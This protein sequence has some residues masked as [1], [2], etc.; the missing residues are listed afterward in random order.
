MSAPESDIGNPPLSQHGIHPK[1]LVRNFAIAG[2]LTFL[3]VTLLL[4]MLFRQISLDNLVEVT[5]ARNVALAT[6]LSHNIW[7]K[8]GEQLPSMSVDVDESLTDSTAFVRMHES[9]LAELATLP[10]LNIKIYSLDGSMLYSASFGE[11]KLSKNHSENFVRASEGETSSQL[12]FREHFRASH[13]VIRDRHVL[14]SYIP[15]RSSNNSPVEG[16]FELYTDVSPVMTGINHTQLL[17][18]TGLIVLLLVIYSALLF[19]VGR[20][21]HV[22]QGHSLA[23]EANHKLMLYQAMHDPLTG[24]LNRK[25]FAEQLKESM[26]QATQES[27]LLAL[28]YMDLD[29]FKQIND[30]FG[31][32]FGDELLKEFA[33]KL[34]HSTRGDDLLSRMGGDEFTIALTSIENIEEVQM[35]AERIISIAQEP[36]MHNGINA[37]FGISMGITIYPLDEADVDTLIKHADTA[38]Y[39]VKEN[40]K[41]NYR[42]YSNEINEE[43][44][45]KTLYVEELKQALQQDQFEVLYQPKVNIVHSRVVGMEALVRW[46]HPQHG[47]I[48][49]AE[50]IPVLE[51][52]GLILEVGEWILRKACETT[53]GWHQQ[54]LDHLVLAVN[55]SPMQFQKDDFIECVAE[56][57]EQ[58]DYPADRLEIEVT[59]GSLIED[60]DD[61]IAKLQS[62][63]DMGVKVAVDDFGTGYSSLSYLQQFPINTLKIDRCFIKQ[64]YESRDNASIVTAIMALAHSM[65]LDVVAEGVEEPQ[66]LAFLSALGCRVIQG[67]LFSRPL[68]AEQFGQ[69]HITDTIV[70]DKMVQEE[71]DLP[72][73]DAI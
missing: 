46:H 66:E 18:M 20:T 71:S 11:R 69:Y 25:G 28:L 26:Q 4:G 13:S 73:Q 53:R 27:R 60:R 23:H 63:R 56:V 24:L 21:A 37:S 42:F 17:F 45:R 14:N 8:Y 40:G 31:H 33:T 34:Q 19:V 9:I 39:D 65:H 1:R 62:L 32:A 41:G 30:S 16:V 43:R 38:M 49:P 50:F 67:Y 29:G 35:V 51:E 12:T 55:V 3:I 61:C 70:Q 5:E 64:L 47:L 22:F 2:F 6:V 68:T 15:I 36:F 58:T 48:S 54:G 72:S 44:L 7:N 57:L 10:I 52:N 59:E